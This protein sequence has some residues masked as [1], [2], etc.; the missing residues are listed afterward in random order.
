M[1][2]PIDWPKIV[3]ILS[4]WQKGPLAEDWVQNASSIIPQEIKRVVSNPMFALD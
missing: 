4:E 3:L 2:D 1:G